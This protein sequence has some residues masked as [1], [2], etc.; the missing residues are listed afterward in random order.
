VVFMR[1]LAINSS[2]LK[3]RGNTEVIL[4][5]FLTGIV[6]ANT[7]AAEPVNIEVVYLADQNI[8]SCLG[9][10]VCWTTTPGVCCQKDDMTELLEKLMSSDVWILASPLY[11]DGV[12][13]SMKNMLD[14]LLPMIVPEISEVDGHCRHALMSGVSGGKIILISTSGFWELDNFEPMVAHINAVSK[15]IHREFVGAL[16]RPHGALLK[17]WIKNT[18]MLDDVLLAARE[19][20]SQLVKAGKLSDDIQNRVSQVIIPMQKYEEIINENFNRL[21]NKGKVKKQ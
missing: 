4:Q 12:T 18:D 10:L 7:G 5:E 6:E 13:G 3:M 11:W 9:K 21:K 17:Y 8:K 16:L 20:G 19:A 2:P 1:I 14:R 15:N